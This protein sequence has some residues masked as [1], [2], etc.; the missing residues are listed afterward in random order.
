M[1]KSRQKL[2]QIIIWIFFGYTL[3]L[4]VISQPKYFQR[5]R[6][7]VPLSPEQNFLWKSS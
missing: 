5:K 1:V 7:K 4:N 3:N 2:L 6:K